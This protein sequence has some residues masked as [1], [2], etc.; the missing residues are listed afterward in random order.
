MTNFRIRP[1]MSCWNEMPAQYKKEYKIYIAK[2]EKRKMEND[3]KFIQ[4]NIP[5]RKK[6][7]AGLNK[8]ANITEKNWFAWME[9]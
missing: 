7:F 1:G 4:K 8:N 3:R 5:R 6:I 9:Y 2:M